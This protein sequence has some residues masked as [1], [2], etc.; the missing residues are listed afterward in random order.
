MAM[1][2]AD[3]FWCGFDPSTDVLNNCI[4]PAESHRAVHYGSVFHPSNSVFNCVKMLAVEAHNLHATIGS[5]E[6][7]A[8]SL[9]CGFQHVL[10][11]MSSG[12]S[13][14]VSVKADDNF[15]EFF[16][17]KPTDLQKWNSIVQANTSMDGWI[18]KLSEKQTDAT[19]SAVETNDDISEFDFYSMKEGAARMFSDSENIDNSFVSPLALSEPPLG[20]VPSPD[21]GK[22]GIFT[23]PLGLVS[24]LPNVPGEGSDA[25][26]IKEGEEDTSDVAISLVKTIEVGMSQL[27]ELTGSQHQCAPFS[28]T[29]V[30]QNSKSSLPC[31]AGCMLFSGTRERQ[32]SKSWFPCL[33]G[34]TIGFTVAIRAPFTDFKPIPWTG[35]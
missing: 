18:P 16:S 29:R 21:S 14:D 19:S 27:R 10:K 13:E 15:W 11:I 1:S 9:T 23:E 24:L 26:L 35:S 32:N 25:M 22:V 28:G 3:A 2:G 12:E 30:K 34:C 7:C 20:F 4:C 8:S 6:K 31:L 5:L 33:T 17:C